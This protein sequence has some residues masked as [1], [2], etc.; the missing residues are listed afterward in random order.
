MEIED[1]IIKLHGL[2]YDILIRH[3][4]DSLGYIHVIKENCTRVLYS[5]DE[6][7][8]FA[9]GLEDNIEVPNCLKPAPAKWI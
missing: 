8:E 4:T 6:L 2:G 5:F 7:I 9:E 1:A 3:D